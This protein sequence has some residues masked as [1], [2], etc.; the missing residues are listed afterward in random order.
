[1]DCGIDGRGRCGG[2]RQCRCQRGLT[3][4]PATSG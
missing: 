4:R 3:Q 2:A 1:M